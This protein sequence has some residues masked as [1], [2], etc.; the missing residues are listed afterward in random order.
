MYLSIIHSLLYLS[1]YDNEL[2]ESIILNT[3]RYVK[4]FCEAI[5]EL[6]SLYKQ[7]DVCLCVYYIVELGRIVNIKFV[8]CSFV[9][10]C[11]ECSHVFLINVALTWIGYR[12]PPNWIIAF[13]VLVS[14]IAVSTWM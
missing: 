7:R 2:A 13:Q 14:P 5:T 6:L 12:K 8:L 4:I 11:F 1:Q 9:K 3:R 10:K